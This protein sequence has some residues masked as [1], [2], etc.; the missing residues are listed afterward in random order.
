MNAKRRSRFSAKTYGWT[1][2]PL[3]HDGNCR[4]L[5]RKDSDRYFQIPQWAISSGIYLQLKLIELKLYIFF[6]CNADRQTRETPSYTTT[7]LAIS[8]RINRKY[9][10]K[11]IDRLASFQLILPFTKGIHI[12]VAVLFDSPLDAILE[13][14]HNNEK[15]SSTSPSL[16]T[17]PLIAESLNSSAHRETWDNLS[18]NL[19]Q[20]DAKSETFRDIRCDNLGQHNTTSPHRPYIPGEDADELEQSR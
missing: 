19:G 4:L 10:G 11:S 9:V 13:H 7:E 5:H 17:S 1:P 2:S 14:A 18:Q 6:I 3:V 20:N 8:C 12:I 16:N 15:T